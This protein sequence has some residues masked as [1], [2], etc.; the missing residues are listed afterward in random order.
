LRPIFYATAL[1]DVAAVWSIGAAVVWNSSSEVL[2]EFVTVWAD[3]DGYFDIA[4]RKGLE[5]GAVVV[6]N[7]HRRVSVRGAND[8]SVEANFVGAE[9]LFGQGNRGRDLSGNCSREQE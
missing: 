4:I 6:A 9:V 1:V 8:G 5:V 3:G 7:D 2:V